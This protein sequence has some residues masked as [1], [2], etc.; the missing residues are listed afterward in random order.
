MSE[1][2]AI[3]SALRHYGIKYTSFSVYKKSVDARR[4]N[5]IKFVITAIVEVPDGE[6]LPLSENVTLFEETVYPPLSLDKKPDK[7][8]IKPVIV[9]FGPCGMFLA[10]LLARK[11][12]CPIVLE[13]GESIEERS[14]TVET[15]LTSKKFS[16]DS[17]VQ[18]GEGGAGA[19][20]DGKLIT[21]VNDKRSH[22][23]LSTLCQFGA[24][25]EILTQAKPHVGTDKLKNVVKNIRLEIIRLGGEVHFNSKVTDIKEC[26]GYCE[27]EI[28]SEEKISAPAIFLA[29][30]HSA[31]DTYKMLLKRGIEI[32]PKDFSVGV[33]IEHLRKDVEYSLYGKA[34]SSPLLPPA[35]YS[36]SYREN[37]RGVYS[38]CMCP[39]G[40]VLASNSDENSIVTNGMSYHKRDGVNSNSALAVS[41]LSSDYGNSPLSA[42]EYQRNIEKLAYKV[43]GDGRAPCQA[44]GD[45]LDGSFT[46]TFSKI[47][48]TYP[49]GVVSAHLDRVLPDKVS[50]LLKTGLRRFGS[51]HSFFSD[52]LALLTGVETRTSSP[53]RI[54]RDKNLRASGFGR[55]YPLGEGAGWAGGITSAALDGL[56]AAESYI[57]GEDYEK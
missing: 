30:G 46:K 3:A 12:Y 27:V 42:I 10:L 17:N 9:G 22:Y 38:F 56:R 21:R 35:E 34:C 55:I 37:G 5:D 54:S 48:P 11:G 26:G 31:H 6:V 36:V 13:R 18:F 53:V 44:V 32:L 16:P 33:R 28:N 49:H 19:F 20:S 50:N 2:E 24:P 4:K 41:V 8:K 43:S 29:T 57:L 23:I 51:Q 52:K 7:D 40:Y 1:S 15:F 39:G 45:F 25:S 14:Q 47:E